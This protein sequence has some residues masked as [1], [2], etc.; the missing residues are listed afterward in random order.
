MNITTNL[1][2]QLLHIT[3][4]LQEN[5]LLQCYLLQLRFHELCHIQSLLHSLLVTH[6]YV[7]N[8]I[9]ILYY[10]HTFLINIS[11]SS[12]L[13]ILLNTHKYNRLINQFHDSLYIYEIDSIQRFF[14]SFFLNRHILIINLSFIIIISFIYSFHVTYSFHATVNRISF[15]TIS[16]IINSYHSFTFIFRN[17]QTH[18]YYQTNQYFHI[19]IITNI[20]INNTFLELYNQ[21]NE[22]SINSMRIQSQ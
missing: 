16:Y 17:K 5:E 22:N 3:L 20:S 8:H 15:N 13:L 2:K 6:K 18:Q 12:L 19:S 14:E 10:H 11:K 7:T 21:F 4:L 9:I 1:H